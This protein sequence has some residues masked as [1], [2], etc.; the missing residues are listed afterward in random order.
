MQVIRVTKAD[1]DQEVFKLLNQ[2]PHQVFQD[3]EHEGSKHVI[4]S[5]LSPH[6]HGDAIFPSM[7]V[8]RYFWACKKLKVPPNFP[9]GELGN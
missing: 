8:R 2:M 5:S 4:R 9:L 3:N 7:L 1:P 6:L